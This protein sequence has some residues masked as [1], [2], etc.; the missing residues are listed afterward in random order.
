MKKQA[1]VIRK[2]VKKGI[3]LCM[4]AALVLS[5]PAGTSYV[6]AA[7]KTAPA[8]KV[9][10]K[11]LYYN[12][13]MLNTYYLKIKKNNS[14]MIVL[15]DWKTSN[16]KVVSLSKKKDASVKLT[17]KKKGKATITANVKYVPKGSYDIKKIRLKCKVTSKYKKIPPELLPVVMPTPTP[18]VPTAA[19]TPAPMNTETPAPTVTPPVDSTAVESVVLDRSDALL[20]V[21]PP[22]NS[23]TLNAEVT[24]QNGDKA[25]Q[26]EITWASD[27]ENIA[28]VD[29]QG[30]VTALRGGTANITATVK[31]VVS[32]PCVIKVDDA[33]PVIDR[34][35]AQGNTFTVYFNEPV[36][37]VSDKPEVSVT[38]NGEQADIKDM[39]VSLAENGESITIKGSNDLAVGEYTIT[40]SGLKDLAGNHME[41]GSCTVVVSEINKV[42]VPETGT[43]SMKYSKDGKDYD[44]SLN[45]EAFNKD[46]EN[47]ED[48]WGMVNSLSQKIDS[49]GTGSSITL[50]RD[51]DGDGKEDDIKFDKTGDGTAEVN[52]TV[53]NETV[54][55][56][57]EFVAGSAGMN[58][59]IISGDGNNESYELYVNED[60]KNK[61]I[62]K[63]TDGETITIEKTE[64]GYTLTASSGF[65][66]TFDK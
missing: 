52:I 46:I 3:A 57:V 13:F 53:N 32:A 39:E 50:F 11:T 29:A 1:K 23:V 42:E 48:I 4:A 17:A 27:D 24:L 22:D 20:G 6:S 19:P 56:N 40:V 62:F 47:H 15:T 44:V 60:N 8:F 12:Y 61:L 51:I 10:K 65:G 14:K 5:V 36:Q 30:V 28:K 43:V 66:I 18:V 7:K 9:K 26:P 25:V 54:K 35:E 49:V 45:M 58:I 55:A 37:Y 16:K 31:G 63:R 38:F 41:Q 64:S 34:A 21:T 59:E 2:A 33:A